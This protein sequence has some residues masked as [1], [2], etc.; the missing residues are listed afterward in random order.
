MKTENLK[1]M[2]SAEE[3]IEKMRRGIVITDQNVLMTIR[4]FP[5]INGDM[6][7][8]VY[9]EYTNNSYVDIERVDK[10]V[11]DTNQELQNL[12]LSLE[13]AY[14][15]LKDGH[16]IYEDERQLK[17]M[18]VRKS[19]EDPETCYVMYHLPWLKG[20]SIDCPLAKFKEIYNNSG[21]VFLRCPDSEGKGEE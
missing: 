1:N 7:E 10:W 19:S 15:E 18:L 12:P 14:K 8:F 20:W 2:E 21:A 5:D 4:S 3:A 17:T 16:Y 6:S 13:D 11:K 9:K